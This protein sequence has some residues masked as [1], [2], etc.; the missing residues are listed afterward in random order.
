MQR[1]NRKSIP[2]SVK[3]MLLEQKQCSNHP[4]HFAVGCKDYI[5]PMWIAYGGYFDESGYQID[6][7][8]EVTHGGGNNIENLQLLCPSCHAVKTKRASRQKW[9][10]DSVE[11]DSGVA[12]MDIGDK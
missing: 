2:A 9:S 4:E 1:S 11:I 3:H 10:F 7:I 12:H 5:C 8:I 6:H